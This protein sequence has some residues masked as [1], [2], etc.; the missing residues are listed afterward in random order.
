MKRFGVILFLF[1]ST[2]FAGNSYH[3]TTTG[4]TG[5]GSLGSPW[6]ISFGLKDSGDVVSPGDT[7][8]IHEGTYSKICTVANMSGTA[9]NPII[10]RNWNNEHVILNSPVYDYIGSDGAPENVITFVGQV[11]HVWLWGLEITCAVTD[12]NGDSGTDDDTVDIFSGVGY[13]QSVG[14]R[15]IHCYLHDVKQP[16]TS[17]S[18]EENTTLYGN[19]VTAFGE[20]EEDRWHGHGVY[21]QNDYNS[22]KYIY[23]NL[24]SRARDGSYAMQIYGSGSADVDSIVIKRNYLQYTILGRGND[25]RHDVNDTVANNFVMFGEFLFGYQ[26]TTT[27]GAVDSNIIINYNYA[28]SLY[29]AHP[30][31]VQVRGNVVGGDGGLNNIGVVT[32]PDSDYDSQNTLLNYMP[33]NPLP[34]DYDTVMTWQSEYEPAWTNIYVA[35]FSNDDSVTVNLSGKY[36]TGDTVRIYNAQDLMGDAP[37]VYVLPADGNIRIAMDTTR[38]TAKQWSGDVNVNEYNNDFLNLARPFVAYSPALWGGR[39]SYT[40]PAT[41]STFRQKGKSKAK[42]Y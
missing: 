35:N 6:R 23:N 38:W 42:R 19:V 37:A 39:Q 40:P 18:A 10:I 32:P 14:K 33:A 30:Y 28:R 15:L 11:D 26:D 21:M 16:I 27:N 9:L 20:L 3:I 41:P 22:F 12:R 17:F 31:N 29:L 7:I 5:D 34:T 1:C 13:S 36:N 8:W 25:S 2:L 4:G 24:I